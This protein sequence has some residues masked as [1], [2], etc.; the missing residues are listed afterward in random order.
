MP[1]I[2]AG[3]V[4]STGIRPATETPELAHLDQLHSGVL[5]ACPLL[6]ATDGLMSTPKAQVQCYLPKKVSFFHSSEH[7]THFQIAKN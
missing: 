5:G 1:L 3:W 2:R 6:N 7:V 4:S